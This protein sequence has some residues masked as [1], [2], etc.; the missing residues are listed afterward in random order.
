[1]AALLVVRRGRIDRG[2]LAGRLFSLGDTLGEALHLPLKLFDQ[3][4]LRGD[5]GVQI[6]NRLVLMDHAHLKLVEAGCVR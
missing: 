3:L 5:G 2:R 6:L 4:P 1:M